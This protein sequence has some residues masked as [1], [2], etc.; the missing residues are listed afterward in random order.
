MRFQYLPR[1]GAKNQQ[2][3]QLTGLCRGD[4]LRAKEVPEGM[5]RSREQ[6]C[7]EHDWVRMQMPG[8]T[9]VELLV[10]IAIMAV[11]AAILFPIVARA[12]VQA[13]IKS[14]LSNEKQLGYALLLY[15]G[16][17]NDKFPYATNWYDNVNE[18]IK[19]YNKSKAVLYCPTTRRGEF[20]EIFGEGARSYHYRNRFPIYTPA[21]ELDWY[22]NY[23]QPTIPGASKIGLFWDVFAYFHEGINVIFCDT[24]ARYVQPAQLKRAR[25]VNGWL[26]IRDISEP[27]PPGSE[28]KNK[29]LR[30]FIQGEPR[31]P[32]KYVAQ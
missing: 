16:D 23:F 28:T 15:A 17:W 12:K 13:R 19:P 1:S 10:V 26:Y 29:Y 25:D 18:Q 30:T 22:K 27:I 5:D 21:G 6:S 8:F 11:L 7:E 2:N 14:C 31:I 20:S 4:R 24:H 3:Y 32:W 9:L